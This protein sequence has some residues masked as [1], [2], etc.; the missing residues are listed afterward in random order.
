[1]CQFPFT[2]CRYWYLLVCLH[3]QSFARF[4]SCFTFGQQKM[5][6]YFC[7]SLISCF[8]HLFLISFSS[9]FEQ[10][11]LIGWKSSI[12]ATTNN[13]ILWNW[14][15]PKAVRWWSHSININFHTKYRLNPIRLCLVFMSSVL[16]F[17][18]V[19]RF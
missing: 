3:F 19:I 4:Q 17:D 11:K 1:M 14:N 13:T 7:I 15:L 8:L 18:G 2:R 5:D 9:Q 10:Q 16:L 6:I 12:M